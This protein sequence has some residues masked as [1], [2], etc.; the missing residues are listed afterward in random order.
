MVADILYR[1]LGELTH[2]LRVDEGL[3][4]AVLGYKID[5]TIYDGIVE[6]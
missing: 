4:V 3:L 6:A 1:I 2:S 5:V